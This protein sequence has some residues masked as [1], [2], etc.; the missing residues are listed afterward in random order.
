MY[1]INYKLTI[2]LHKGEAFSKDLKLFFQH[3]CPRSFSSC[4]TTICSVF[5]YFSSSSSS[6]TLHCGTTVS[7]NSPVDFMCVLSFFE[8]TQF[9]HFPSMNTLHAY[10]KTCFG[11]VCMELGYRFILCLF[12]IFLSSFPPSDAQM[13]F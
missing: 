5:L 13:K 9:S 10:C 12:Q 1:Y 11:L 7:F 8:Y 3:F 2:N 4:L 6:S